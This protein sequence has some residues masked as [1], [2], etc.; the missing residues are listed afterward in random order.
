MSS[1]NVGEI[2]ANLHHQLARSVKG[3][4]PTEIH[5]LD[6]TCKNQPLALAGK[7][8]GRGGVRKKPAGLTLSELI[9]LVDVKR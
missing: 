7:H 9:E 8:H 1:K 2:L 4:I 3:C 6:Q 5:T